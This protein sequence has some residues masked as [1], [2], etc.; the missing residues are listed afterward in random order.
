M[1][2]AEKITTGVDKLVDLI[3][4]KKRVSVEQAAR[5]LSVPKVLVEEW[6]D[7]LDEREVIG[8]EYKVAVPYLTFKEITKEEVK[9]RAKIF[10]GRKEGF[11]RKVESVLQLL[12]NESDSL[13]KIKEEFESAIGQK[14]V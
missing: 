12:E 7:F 10:V 6:A 2:E 5:T 1:V 9:E 8:I 13:G 11:V 3:K 4:I 14:N